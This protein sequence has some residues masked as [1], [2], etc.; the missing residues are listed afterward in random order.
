MALQENWDQLTK[1]KIV[2][3]K[4]NNAIYKFEGYMEMPDGAMIS[5]GAENMI[6]RG[7]KL[8]NTEEVYGISIFTG[9]DSK[10]MQNSTNAKYKFSTLELMNNKAILCVLLTQFTI[11]SISSMMGTNWMFDEAV[12]NSSG[13][14]PA[15]YL[16]YQYRSQYIRSQ[17]NYDASDEHIDGA[18][19]SWIKLTLT[20]I[21]ILT[22]LLP[23]SMMV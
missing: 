5:L 7:C 11:A 22:N 23:I 19:V 12:K 2:C 14:T 4:P 6:L 16:E 3:E 20:F 13:E 15:W 21:I 1:A 17:P 10:I 18:F 9:H 8:R